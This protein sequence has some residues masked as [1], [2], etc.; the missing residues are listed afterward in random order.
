MSTLGDVHVRICGQEIIKYDLEI[1]AQIQDIRDCHGPQSSLLE[2]NSQV[3]EKFIKLRMRIQDLELMAREQDRETDRQS[4]QAEAESQRRQM[5][6]NQTAWRKANLCCQLL[7]DNM[8]IDELLHGGDNQ[9]M[10]HRK[11][12]KES[13]VESSS[14]ITESLMSISR[15]MAERVKQSEDSIGVLATSS[16]TV[17]ETNEEFKNMTGTIH[18]G[19]KLILKYNRRELTDKLLIFLALALFLATVLYILKKR[20]FPFI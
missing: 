14:N 16:R 4:I 10:R 3:K 5:L 15:M 2:L 1:K 11:V 19:R 18:L 17:Q 7:I 12:T 6:S 9:S 13:L 20:F 8:E